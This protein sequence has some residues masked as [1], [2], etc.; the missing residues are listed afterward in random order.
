MSRARFTK[1]EA[2]AK[3]G[4]R[5]KSLVEFA[6]IPK[7]TTGQAVK[8]DDMGDGWDVVIQWDIPQTPLS[9]IEKEVAGESVLVIDAG[10][11]LRDW[12]TKQEGV[13]A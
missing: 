10:A 6:S 5:I 3:V 9:V 7:G 12:F 2:E 1:A 11:P 4:R 13:V 8:A